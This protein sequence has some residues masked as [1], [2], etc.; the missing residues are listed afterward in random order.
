MCLKGSAE[1]LPDRLALQAQA[2]QSHL[3]RRATCLVIPTVHV[4]AAD[5]TMHGTGER[6]AETSTCSA[7]SNSFGLFFMPQKR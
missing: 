3:R 4:G 5:T 2:K 7:T 1:V 6:N